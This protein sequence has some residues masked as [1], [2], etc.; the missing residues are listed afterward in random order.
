MV[1]WTA[2][3]ARG[4]KALAFGAKARGAY[5]AVN[6][7]SGGRVSKTLDANKGKI[8]GWV[9][10]KLRLNKIGLINKAVS[11]TH[12]TLPTTERV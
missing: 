5:D 2:L 4:T 12:L 3:G 8:G 11:Y 9:A 7:M 10:K 1:A 6:K